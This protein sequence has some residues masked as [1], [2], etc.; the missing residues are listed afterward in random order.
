MRDYG[1]HLIQAGAWIVYTYSEGG[2][3]SPL[4]RFGRVLVVA[5]DAITVE[6]VERWG[7]D[8]RKL[9]RPSS[10]R[11]LGSDTGHPL[12]SSPRPS[13]VGDCS[14]RLYG[15]G[16]GRLGAIRRTVRH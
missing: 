12:A 8:W 5:D 4:M 15:E 11:V 13:S 2:T 14:R 10:L 3:R 16:D 6:A 9:R 7:E 1:G